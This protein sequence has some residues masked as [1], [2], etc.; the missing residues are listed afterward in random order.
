MVLN[1]DLYYKNRIAQHCLLFLYPSRAIQ[2]FPTLW[3]SISFIDS[4]NTV[5]LDIT[6]TRAYTA[7]LGPARPFI[8]L[9]SCSE[10]AWVLWRVFLIRNTRRH[11]CATPRTLHTSGSASRPVSCSECISHI[12]YLW[13]SASCWC[14]LVLWRSLAWAYL[15]YRLCFLHIVI[16]ELL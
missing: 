3:F 9:I 13:P 5:A 12:L 14:L 11:T 4:N 2:D 1:E 6:N 10:K 7:Q 16:R 8:A 15:T